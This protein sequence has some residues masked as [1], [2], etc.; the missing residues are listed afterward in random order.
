MAVNQG[1]LKQRHAP[2][3]SPKCYRDS[4]AP[5]PPLSFPQTPELRSLNFRYNV[6]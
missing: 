6:V 4:G 2:L 1:Q 5:P 3:N